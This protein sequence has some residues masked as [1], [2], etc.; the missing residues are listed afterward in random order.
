MGA[1]VDSGGCEDVDGVCNVT[2]IAPAVGRIGSDG[3]CS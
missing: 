2:S 3:G 1:V